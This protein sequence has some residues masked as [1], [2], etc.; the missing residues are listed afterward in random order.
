M[1]FSIKFEAVMFGWRGVHLSH[2]CL[3][4]ANCPENVNYIFAN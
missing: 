2:F 3:F 4:F 1:E